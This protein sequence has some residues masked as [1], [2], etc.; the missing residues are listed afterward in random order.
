M[1]SSAE[2]RA[3]AE[4]AQAESD[5]LAA[6]SQ[7]RAQDAAAYRDFSVEAASIEQE[8]GALDERKRALA[9]RIGQVAGGPVPE[10]ADGS[11]K[12][13]TA[14]LRVASAPGGREHDPEK[15]LLGR[16]L[17]SERARAVRVLGARKRDLASVILY[18]LTAFGRMRTGGLVEVMLALRIGP[19]KSVD[20]H[21]YVKS[22]VSELRRDGRVAN[23][24]P[25]WLLPERREA[26]VGPV[27]TLATPLRPTLSIV[28]DD[29]L[30]SELEAAQ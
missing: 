8:Q 4:E 26:E 16:N 3:R 9:E 15:P 17:Q 10:S 27:V 23:D 30:G 13:E 2:L 18:I 5:V 1:M 22:K 29:D 7:A 28:P 25:F 20:L 12:W 14:A 21:N 6:R 11:Q 19:T 24:K